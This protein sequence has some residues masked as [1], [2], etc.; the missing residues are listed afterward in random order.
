MSSSFTEAI[1]SSSQ[2]KEVSLRTYVEQALQRY[3]A[4]LDG[5]NPANVYGM[6]LEEMEVP[7]L[8]AVL[9][10]TRG[11]QVKAAVILGLSRGTLR[12]KMK[13]YHLD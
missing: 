11:N 1:I 3:F 6:V 2:Q 13:Q 5:H 7:L 12:K 4:R 9:R 8:K 10:Y